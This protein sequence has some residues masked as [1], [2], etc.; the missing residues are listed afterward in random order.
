MSKLARNYFPA[1]RYGAKVRPQEILGFGL[2]PHVGDIWYVD[3]VNGLD[4]NSGKSQDEAFASLYKAHSSATTNNFDV[5]LVT[6][7]GTG[8]GS[9]TNESAAV[10]DGLWTFSK[11]LITVVGVCAPSLVSP[12]SR[13]LWD[14]ASQSTSTALLTISGSGNSFYNIQLA[15][16]VDNN[17][18]VTLTGDRNYFNA[19]HFAGIGDAT[20]GDDTAAITLDINDGDENVF[21]ECVIGLDTVARSTTNTELKLSGETQRN[22][23][24]DCFFPTFADNAGHTFVN[25]SSSGAIDRWHLFQRCIFHNATNSTATAMTVAMDTHASAGGSII[26]HDSWLF[27]ATD[28]ADDFTVVEVAGGAQATGA[29]AGLMVAAA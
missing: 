2:A 20:A 12:R 26:L 18:L 1:L 7:E 17:I 16:F 8:S 28:W 5:I 11:N 15:S 25:A 14:T 4:T 6:S 3:G 21:D 19:V 24:R 22:I 23:F 10:T 29:T 27:G 9:G 13:I